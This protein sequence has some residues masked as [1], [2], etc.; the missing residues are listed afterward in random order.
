VRYWRHSVFADLAF[1]RAA[2]KVVVEVERL[3]DHQLVLASPGRT[4]I[5]RA[6]VIVLAPGGTHPFRSAGALEQD[7]DWLRDWN[8]GVRAA[9]AAGEPLVESEP[10]RRELGPAGHDE[11][12]SSL[13]SERL[14]RLRIDPDAD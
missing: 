4:A 8:A 7:D 14:E 2:R 10:V 9:L 13:G 5:H 11:Y 12:L 3:V 1:A 6:D